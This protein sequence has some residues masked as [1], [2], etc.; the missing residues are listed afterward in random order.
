MNES[1]NPDLNG[2]WEHKRDK[3]EIED[4]CLKCKFGLLKRGQHIFCTH[5]QHP[6]EVGGC[7]REWMLNCIHFDD[8]LP[9]LKEITTYKRI[10][11][12]KGRDD[13]P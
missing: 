3:Q 2:Y 8:S 13:L 7:G 4:H 10:D 6:G 9:A 11:P 1:N 12:K 5:W